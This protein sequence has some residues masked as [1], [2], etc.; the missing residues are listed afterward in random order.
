MNS[1]NKSLL[2]KLVSQFKEAHQ[3]RAPKQ[4][5]MEPLALVSLGIRR[6]VAPMVAGVRVTCREIEKIEVA[7]PGQGTS[8]GVLL[9]TKEKRIVA[10]DLVA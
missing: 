2:S 8:L 4:V 9:D 6:D 7:K 5:V 1:K 10:C 3:G